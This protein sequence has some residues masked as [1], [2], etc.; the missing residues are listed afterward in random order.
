MEICELSSTVHPFMFSVQFHPEFKSRPNRPSPPF[1]AFLAVSG[2]YRDRMHRAGLLW[3][4]YE[5]A[6]IPALCS[7][8]LRHNP[9]SPK[10]LV[11]SRSKSVSAG[12]P[13]ALAS[14]GMST[15]VSDVKRTAESAEEM[16]ESAKRR[17]LDDNR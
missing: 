12:S 9:M 15:P 16:S 10:A 17:R 11:K 14:N 4:E 8:F 6:S 13:N 1:F 3:R 5:A 2:G 7:P